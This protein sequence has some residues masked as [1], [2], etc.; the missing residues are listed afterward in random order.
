MADLTLAQF[1]VIAKLLRSKEPAATAAKLVLVDGL[2]VKDVV[3]KT[4]MSQPSVSQAAK[5]Y[6]DA[7][8]LILT[9]YSSRKK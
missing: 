4:G 5:R 3:L 7:H 8:D 1:E 2:A 6:R 9:G